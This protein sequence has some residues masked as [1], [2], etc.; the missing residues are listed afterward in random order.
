MDLQPLWQG[1]RGQAGGGHRS[2]VQATWG[3]GAHT[4]EPSAP[5]T[6]QGEHICVGPSQRFALH[7]F[8]KISG[9]REPR[10]ADMPP[11][12]GGTNP[13]DAHGDLLASSPT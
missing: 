10:L 2:A 6:R 3:G 1:M 11:S 9:R 7:V 8:S 5:P 4:P 13:R 12:Y